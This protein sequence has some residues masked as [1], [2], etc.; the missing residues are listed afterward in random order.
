MALAPILAPV[1]T[2]LSFSLAPAPMVQLKRTAKK[3]RGGVGGEVGRKDK[4]KTAAKGVENKMQP[5][6]PATDIDAGKAVVKM[7]EMHAPSR[8][9]ESL[10]RLWGSGR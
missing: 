2:T 3:K 9:L 4:P 1:M 7:H 5:C 6:Q 10:E 8:V